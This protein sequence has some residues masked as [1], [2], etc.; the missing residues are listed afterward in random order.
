MQRKSARRQQWLILFVRLSLGFSATGCKPASDSTSSPAPAPVAAAP[1][2]SPTTAPDSYVVI[3][4][5]GWIPDPAT[6]PL[7]TRDS[8]LVEGWMQ[9]PAIG[10]AEKV[11]PNL[12]HLEINPPSQFIP[13]PYAPPQPQS[14]IN[15]PNYSNLAGL[16]H[17]EDPNGKRG[18]LPMDDL[19]PQ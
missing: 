16:A 8:L 9:P 12:N 18:Y 19:R 15:P 13:N 2:T 1:T 10:A 3:K 17:I 14:I 7:Q 11:I 6:Q 5:D 4:T